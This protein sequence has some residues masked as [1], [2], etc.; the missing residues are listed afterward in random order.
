MQTISILEKNK[1][2]IVIK[3]PRKL[4]G[5]MNFAVEKLTE[6]QALKILRIGMEEYKTKKTKKLASLYDLRHGN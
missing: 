5:R 4:M 2:Y 1:D 3:V 6:S